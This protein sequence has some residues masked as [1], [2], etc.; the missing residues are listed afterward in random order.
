MNIHHYFDQLSKEDQ[1]GVDQVYNAAEA[2]LVSLGYATLGDDRAE[3]LCD[4]IARY[5]IE[6][7]SSAFRKLGADRG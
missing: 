6:V 4:A 1:E 3:R 2:K 5:I 7:R